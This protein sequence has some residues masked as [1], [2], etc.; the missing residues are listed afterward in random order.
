MVY[1]D[2]TELKWMPYVQT[3]M[4]E[5]CGRMKEELKEYVLELFNRYVENGLRFIQK[6][7]T[8]AMPQVDISKVQT[9]C[10]L[11][12][13]LVLE[14]RSVDLSVDPAKL[15]PLICT[16][17]VFCYLWAIGGNIIDSCWDVFDTF[18]R[19]QFEDNGDAKVGD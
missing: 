17:F 7:C 19:Q 5:K 4:A 11:F 6:K 16:T 3:W 10:K 14:S 2:A 12:E 15:N 9:L 13:S 8:E 18:V 1:V